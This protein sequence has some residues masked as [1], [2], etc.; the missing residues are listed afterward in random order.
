MSLSPQQ[1]RVVAERCE[2][3]RGSKAPDGYPNSLALCIVDSVQSTMVRYPTVEKVVKNYRA[4][5][6]EHGADPNADSAADLAATFAQLGGH[7]AWAKRIGN[8]NRTSTHRGAPL[9]A[10]AIEVEAKNMIDLGV[11]NAEDLRIAAED[12]DALAKVKKAWLKGSRSGAGCHV[13]LRPDAGRDSRYQARPND[14]PVC[15]KRARSSSQDCRCSFLRRPADRGRRRTID[16]RQR[17]GP[18]DLEL[19]TRSVTRRQVD[20]LDGSGIP[21]AADVLD[22]GDRPYVSKIGLVAGS[23]RVDADNLRLWPLRNADAVAHGGDHGAF[24]DVSDDN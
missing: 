8:G 13:A 14:R 4:Y 15:R 20:E 9:K 3:F 12:P 10:Y 7:E 2:Q 6:R 21:V 19:P 5:R 17:T 18:C 23:T 1:V 24:G 22:L 16:D 11:L